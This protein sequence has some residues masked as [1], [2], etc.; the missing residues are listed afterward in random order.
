M[1]AKV[2]V[3]LLNEDQEFQQLQAQD[4]REA[5]RRLGLEVEVHFAQ[6]HAVVQIQQLFKHIHADASARPAALVVEAAAG[7]GLERVARNAVK[8]GIGWVL[9]NMAPAYLDTLRR[10]PRAPDRDGRQRPEGSR[11]NPGPP[12]AA[13]RRQAGPGALR[14]GTGGFHREPGAPRGAQGDARCG[15]PSSAR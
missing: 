9:V 2:V 8:A 7:E 3:A 15:P 13:A 4:A 11:A 10:S 5:G 14:A 1:P 6:G 12:G